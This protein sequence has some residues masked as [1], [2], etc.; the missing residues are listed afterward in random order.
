[1][2]IAPAQTQRFEATVQGS[3]ALEWLVNGIPGGN[4]DVGTVDATGNYVA[5]AKLPLSTNVTVTAA[6]VA[7][8]QA[9]YATAVASIINPGIVTATANPQ[10]ATYS[11]YLPAPGRA[12]V[13]FGPDTNYGLM[14]WEQSTPSPNGGQVSVYVAGM[15]ARTRY[16]M[17]AQ[18]TLD[19]GST[20]TDIDQTFTTGTPPGTALVSTSTSGGQIPQ[21]GIELFDTLTP[22]EAAQAFA[23][24]L[25]GNVIWTYS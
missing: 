6:L 20:L 1:V 9:N 16:H 3:A 14:T 13:D 22:N 18:L 21:Q 12:S 15:R 10:V 11:I 25:Q 8:P 19:D 17:R 5:P 24:D 23:T 7:S 4:A 2:A